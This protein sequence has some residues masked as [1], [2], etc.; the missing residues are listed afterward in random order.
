MKWKRTGAVVLPAV[1]LLMLAAC[2]QAGDNGAGKYAEGLKEL[3][4]IRVLARE[5]GSGTRDAFA[6]LVGL[7]SSDGTKADD[8]REDAEIMEGTDE[9]KAAAAADPAALGYVS[10]GAL[11]EG[12][13]SVKILSV[14]GRKADIQS[15]AEGKYRL[16]R[17]FYLVYVGKA[18]GLQQDFLRYI[19]GKGQDIVGQ[20]FVPVSKTEVFLSER[21]SGTL[22]ICGST[23]MAPLMRELAEAYEKENPNAHIQITE[24]DSSAGLKE[25]MEGS[26]DFGMCSR[27]LKS[28]EKEILNYELAARDGIA[29]IVNGQ[30]PLEDIT[31]EQLRGIYSG[32]ISRW[33]ELNP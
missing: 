6:G 15:V 21:P 22:E 11:K 27:E 4:T 10:M 2:Q 13:D 1:L 25:A 8:T 3:G 28:Y 19:T 23:S 26:C 29:V 16:S 33:E 24:S 7:E 30:N 9:I 12:E 5:E 14:E 31:S 17:P 32:E 18:D 20:L